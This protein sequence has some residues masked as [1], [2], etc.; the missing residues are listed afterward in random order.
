MRAEATPPAPV[1]FAGHGSLM[2][3]IAANAFSKSPVRLGNTLEKPK[4]IL[5][6]SAHW[7]ENT[8]AVSVHDHGGTEILDAF[9]AADALLGA[10]VSE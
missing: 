5:V 9:I 6:V 3:A 4:S 8:F 1:L 7:Q 2:N 10:F